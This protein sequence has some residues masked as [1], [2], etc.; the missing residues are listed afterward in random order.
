MK[1]KVHEITRQVYISTENTKELY[2]LGRLSAKFVKSSVCSSNDGSGNKE[3]TI[4][5][6][7]L[8]N[9]LAE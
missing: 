5:V 7:E 6:E 2:V 1:I 8:I 3:L 9:K 4:G